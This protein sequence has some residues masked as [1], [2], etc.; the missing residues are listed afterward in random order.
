VKRAVLLAKGNLITPQEFPAEIVTFTPALAEPAR[1][2]GVPAAY[3][4]AD[5]YDTDLKSINERNEKEMILQMLERVK[6]NKSKAARLLN[7]DRK[8]LYNKLKL[9]DIEA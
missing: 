3:A 7:I 6:Y 4:G 2:N 1:V 9:Y 8:T 5:A